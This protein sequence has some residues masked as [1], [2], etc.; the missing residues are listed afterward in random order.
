MRFACTAKSA[1]IG[2]GIGNIRGS[3]SLKPVDCSLSKTSFAEGLRQHGVLG[4]RSEDRQTGAGMRRW[5]RRVWTFLTSTLLLSGMFGKQRGGSEMYSM[6]KAECITIP[7]QSCRKGGSCCV[8]TV[9]SPDGGRR[10]L[11]AIVDTGSPYLTIPHNV[12]NQGMTAKF[13]TSFSP[14][15][16]TYGS[17][18]GNMTW[19][20]GILEL[21]PLPSSNIDFGV[22]DMNISKVSGGGALLGIIK[23]SNPASTKIMMRPTV[24]DQ[25]SISSSPIASFKMDTP[26]GELVLS[27]KP[28]ISAAAD[29]LKLVD[30]RPLGDTVDHY[31]CR[32]TKLRLDGF[33]VLSGDMV[34]KQVVAV[35][36]TGLRRVAIPSSATCLHILVLLY[37]S[38]IKHLKLDF[39]VPSYISTSY[40][41]TCWPLHVVY[42]HTKY[43]KK[44]PSTT[45][46]DGQKYFFPDMSGSLV[47]LPLLPLPDA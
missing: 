28:L 4:I 3:S 42:E 1:W 14:T 47:S 40:Q 41:Q 11:S 29:A 13:P 27:T 21:L 31:A 30:L 5:T 19:L 35:L 9:S 22:A 39:L 25:I 17:V 8:L 10:Q 12:I 38:K 6:G 20:N 46:S 26:A 34:T 33:D 43:P 37:M 45:C 24:L 15:T 16:E 18:T 2:T 36:D 7:L 32:V 23:Y 44:T